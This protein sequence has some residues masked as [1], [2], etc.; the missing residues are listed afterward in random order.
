MRAA[1]VEV[2][3]LLNAAEHYDNDKEKGLEL[4]EIQE[5]LQTHWSVQRGVKPAVVL[6]LLLRNRMADHVPGTSHSWTRGRD[7]GPHYRINGAGKA[8][9]KEYI[10]ETQRVG[11]G[12]A[13]RI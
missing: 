10:D 5:G 3:R 8:F 7:F 2:L 9:L 1:L 6:G 4:D 13:H 12:G 11:G